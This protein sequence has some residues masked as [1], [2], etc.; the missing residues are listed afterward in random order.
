MTSK[1]LWTLCLTTSLFAEVETLSLKHAVDLALRQNPDIL[2]ARLDEQKAVLGVQ[3]ARDPFYPK[4]FVGSGLAYSNGFP[5]SIEGAAPSVVQSRAVGSI[6]NKPQSWAIQQAK[7]TARGSAIDVET[8]QDE[9]AIRTAQ[10][11]LDARRA[12]RGADVSRRQMESLNK[13]LDTV[14]ARVREG[15]ELEIEAKKAELNVAMIRQRAEAFESERHYLESALAAVLGLSIGDRVVAID[16]PLTGIEVPDT[17][18]DCVRAAIE[19]SK[20]L[21]KLQS[22]LAAKGFE[23]KISKS[24]HYPKVDLVAQYGLFAKFNHYEDYFRTFKQHNGQ[25]GVSFQLP[26]FASKAAR[27]QAA[28][29]ALESSQLRIQVNQTRGRISMET[30]RQ[31]QAVRVAETSREVSKLSLDVAREQVTLLLVQMEEGRATLRQLE[32]ARFAENEKWTAF[33]DAQHTLER[34]KLDLLK[35]TGT[36]LAVLK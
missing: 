25:L 16:E 9:I 34:A 26:V 19:S 21:R 13:V 10:L 8:K 31:F 22:N 35:T 24:S 17:E 27:A 6:Y 23:A 30:R 2:L 20:E 15:R 28:Q 29:A 7:E 1:L 36:L 5:M 12:S 33:Y 11:Y 18:E 3:V 32:E 4:L 14:R